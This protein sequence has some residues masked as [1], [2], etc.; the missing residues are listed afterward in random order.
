MI[1]VEMHGRLGNQLF[2]YAAARRIQL[3]TNKNI[4]MN[5]KKVTGVNSE[6]NTGWEDS[7]KDFCV[8]D[9]VSTKDC[10]NLFENLSVTKRILCVIYAFSYKPFMKNID[11]WYNYQRKWCPFLD[12]LGI[13]WIANGYYDFKHNEIE[14]ILL[15]GSFEAPQYFDSIRDILVEEI[16]P[17][18]ERLEQNEELYSIIENTNSVC[19][20]LRHFQLHGHQK[21]LYDVCS[22]EYYNSAIEYIKQKV[23]NPHF[24]FFSDDIDWIKTVVD[25]SNLSYSLETLNNPL[26]EKLRLMYSCKH[27]IIPN[28]TFAWWAQYLGRHKEKIVISPAI[29]FNDDFKS[30]LI[31]PSWIKIDVDGK[32][33]E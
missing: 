16:Q 11:R 3:E 33:I 7:L 9:Y 2:Q 21:N 4:V 24:I 1:Y 5:F 32:V 15:N 8:Y 10:N 13:R 26:W 14:D 28:S 23:E 29:W 30:P 12:K 6:G 17:K 31:S 25:V 27:F 19:V 22:Q 18:Y 20:S